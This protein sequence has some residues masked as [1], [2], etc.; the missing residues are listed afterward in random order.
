MVSI[1]KTGTMEV[2]CLP[3]KWPSSHKFDMA[4]AKYDCVYIEYPTTL[5]T[6]ESGSILSEDPASE[7]SLQLISKW[8][9]NC[10][11]FHPECSRSPKG[12][13]GRPKPP[14]RV[15]AVE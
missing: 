13:N 15:I 12:R 1:K 9:S 14:T 8:L 11:K 10:L 4:F 5:N 6:V 3:G 2:F 7:S